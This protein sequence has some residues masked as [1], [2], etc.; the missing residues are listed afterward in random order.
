LIG[1]GSHQ[2]ALVAATTFRPSCPQRSART[3]WLND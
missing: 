3:G 2:E 1:L